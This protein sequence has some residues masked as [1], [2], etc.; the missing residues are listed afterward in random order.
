MT[1]FA[2]V[3]LNLIS[4]SVSA[5]EDAAR[6]SGLSQ[7]DAANQAIQFWAFVQLVRT[8]GGALYVRE[9]PDSEMREVHF[10]TSNG[11]CRD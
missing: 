1:D 8:H 5:L 6:L 10:V 4:K 2:E 7:T 9:T 11:S 3:P